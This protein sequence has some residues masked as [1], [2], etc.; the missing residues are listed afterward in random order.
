MVIWHGGITAVAI[1]T[2][3]SDRTIRNGIKELH[4]SSSLDFSRQRRVDGG[5]KRLEYHNQTLHQAVEGLI[6]PTERG[7]PQSPLRWTCK[8]LTNLQS[9]FVISLATGEVFR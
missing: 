9:G 1:A 3:L 5:C 7:D 8:S 6:E 4:S 2:G